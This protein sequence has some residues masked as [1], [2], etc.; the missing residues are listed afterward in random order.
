MTQGVQ[1]S[2]QQQ[3]QRQPPELLQIQHNIP[4]MSKKGHR[5]LVDGRVAIDIHL[6]ES[7]FCISEGIQA[8]K[9]G[10]A[11]LELDP[12]GQNEHPGPLYHPSFHKK[13]PAVKKSVYTQIYIH[14]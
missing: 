8:T 9:R 12:S 4:I 11:A 5:W 10:L 7:F 14:K 13:K 6:E 3:Q 2:W 1:I